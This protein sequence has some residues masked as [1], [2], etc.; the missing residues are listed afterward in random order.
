MDGFALEKIRQ[1]LA[2]VEDFLVSDN[3][4]RIW[5]GGASDWVSF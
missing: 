3:L 4:S 2:T 5:A 1:E